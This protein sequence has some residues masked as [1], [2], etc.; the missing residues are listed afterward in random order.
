MGYLVL[1]MEWVESF[2]TATR[3]FIKATT[4]EGTQAYFQ[5]VADGE[6]DCLYLW[7]KLYQ[8]DMSSS[9]QRYA[10]SEPRRSSFLRHGE[11]YYPYRKN[12]KFA[13]AFGK[14]N[15]KQVRGYLREHKIKVQKASDYQISQ[16]MQHLNSSVYE[17]D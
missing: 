8:L 11:T 12:R 13:K 14:E 6:F 2:R 4:P 10:F 1:G 7:S 16:L 9:S 17:T 5:L 3:R 15:R